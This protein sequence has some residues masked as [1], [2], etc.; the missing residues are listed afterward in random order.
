M[1]CVRIISQEKKITKD[2]KVAEKSLNISIGA[3]NSVQQ[4]AKMALQVNFFS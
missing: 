4:A 2:R 1:K 3:L